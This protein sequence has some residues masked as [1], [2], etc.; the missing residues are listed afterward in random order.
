MAGAAPHAFCRAYHART[1]KLLTAMFELHPRGLDYEL[2]FF[3]QWCGNSN[4]NPRR[5]PFF[6]STAWPDLT[7]SP[8]VDDVKLKWP[9]SVTTIQDLA[10]FITAFE[11]SPFK[12]LVMP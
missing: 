6:D 10:A 8:S 5:H 2:R 12:E 1:N 11:A 3:L 4:G 9:T 7:A